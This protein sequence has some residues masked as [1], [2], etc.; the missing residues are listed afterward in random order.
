MYRYC[1]ANSAYCAIFPSNGILLCQF[2]TKAHAWFVGTKLYKKNL[3][4]FVQK[5][6]MT[7]RTKVGILI[8][9]TLVMGFGFFMMLRK[10]LTIPCV[11]LAI[12]WI[13]HMVYFL[14]GIKT[15]PEIDLK[16]GSRKQEIC[17]QE[18]K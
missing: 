5:K 1:T 3:E 11:I 9:S 15:I 12:V 16:Q 14:F 7:V 8:T 17:L 13:G 2:F 18:E 10:S 6:G 4:S